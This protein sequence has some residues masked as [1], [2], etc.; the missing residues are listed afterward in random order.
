MVS[1]PCR[2]SLDNLLF[3][4]LPLIDRIFIE[5]FDISIHSLLPS[6]LKPSTTTPDVVDGETIQLSTT[7][8]VVRF[9]KKSFSA[10][11]LRMIIETFAIG[12]AVFFCAVY[13]PKVDVI[14]S[15]TGS[16]A[17]TCVSYI[18]PGLFYT[19]LARET[20]PQKK[21]Y[22]WDIILGHFV[23]IFGICFG[24]FVTTISIIDLVKPG[25]LLH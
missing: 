17:S 2:L 20:Y 23:T 16:T 19:K 1:Y 12:I 9:F 7:D 5:I 14:L 3:D 11:R 25:L 8:K 15:L 24:I 4:I 22:S 18:L 10:E 6:T 21:W 13:F